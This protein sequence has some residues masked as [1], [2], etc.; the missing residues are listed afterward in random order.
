M[1]CRI[2]LATAIWALSVISGCGRAAKEPEPPAK[3][4]PILES[5]EMPDNRESD[6]A[7]V[8]LGGP[9]HLRGSHQRRE[10]TAKQEE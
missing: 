2:M 7:T 10:L 5:P 6:H 8:D 9:C 1:R 3:P 4:T